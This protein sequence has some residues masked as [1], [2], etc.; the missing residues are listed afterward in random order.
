[1]MI[2]YD[3]DYDDCGK[4]TVIY[5]DNSDNLTN[6]HCVRLQYKHTLQTLV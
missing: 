5:D 3:S 2:N 1:M 6:N 4:M